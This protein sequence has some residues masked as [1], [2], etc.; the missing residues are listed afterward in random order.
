MGILRMTV[1][2]MVRAMCG[3]QL[4]DRKRS[5]DLFMVGSSETT[6]GG[7]SKQCSLVWS[8]VERGWSCFEKGITF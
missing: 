4:K 8:C 3:V 2:S 6:D 1:R 5:T 7:H